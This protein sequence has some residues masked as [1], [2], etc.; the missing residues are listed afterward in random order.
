MTIR[1][2]DLGIM[3]YDQYGQADSKVNYVSYN[4]RMNNKPVSK[5]NAVSSSTSKERSVAKDAREDYVRGSTPAYSIEFTS[6]GMSALKSLKLFKENAENVSVNDT[7]VTD[8]DTKSAVYATDNENKEP[9]IESTRSDSIRGV[10]EP[11]KNTGANISGVKAH[12][13]RQNHIAQAAVNT[14][15]TS[16]IGNGTAKQNQAAKAY[17]FQ[18]SFGNS[19]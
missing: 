8:D 13:N 11:K 2:S 15:R 19:R 7:K 4:E 3:R 17:E 6:G 5:V 14:R 10:N 18:M 1:V 12:E 16:G 9:V